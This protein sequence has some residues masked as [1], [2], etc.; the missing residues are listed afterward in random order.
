MAVNTTLPCVHERNQNT[1]QIWQQI[2][3]KSHTCQHDLISSG[4]LAKEGIDIVALQEPSI[5]EFGNTVSARDWTIIFLSTHNTQ[6]T[7][8]RSITLICS[9]MLTDNW[10]QIDINSEDIMAVEIRGTWGTLAFFNTYI[11]CEHD[12]VLEEL[13]RVSKAYKSENNGNERQ[14]KHIIWLGGFQQT[15][16]TLGQPRKDLCLFT[17]EALHNVEKAYQPCHGCRA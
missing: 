8:T 16:P 3:N 5:N 15:P 2:L 11:D 9:D 12:Q 14:P 10:S 7:K 17:R 13:A 4:K 6:P 1:L